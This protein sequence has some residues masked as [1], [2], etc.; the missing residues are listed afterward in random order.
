MQIFKLVSNSVVICTDQYATLDSTGLRG[1]DW[2]N[3]T[4]AGLVTQ[5]TCTALP[6]YYLDNCY[7]YLNG[8]W[9]IVNQ[10]AVT[11]YTNQQTAI[12]W[13]AY[14]SQAQAALDKTDVTVARVTEGVIKG[15]CAFANADVVA[16]MNY[17]E[18]LRAILTQVQPTTIP[19]SLPTRPANPAGS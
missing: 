18:S 6:Q 3:P 2:F 4:V 16:F 7:S 11:E 9:T 19:T 15:T 17:R 8:V 12:Q 14:Q 1:R 10:I 13:Q 5:D